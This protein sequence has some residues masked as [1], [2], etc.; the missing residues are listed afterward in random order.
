M[1][2]FLH[3]T[4][5]APPPPGKEAGHM[6]QGV[7]AQAETSR[8]VKSRTQT[9]T[10]RTLAQHMR[11]SIE[12]KNRVFRGRSYPNSFIGSDAI[13]YLINEGLVETVKDGES[14]GEALI[15]AGEIV[16]V[17]KEHG[18]KNKG[19]FYYFAQ[20]A[21][22]HGGVTQRSSS[23]PPQSWTHLFH[24]LGK[25]QT[26]TDSTYQPQIISALANGDLNSTAIDDL[27]NRELKQSGSTLKKLNI[28][29]L[30]KHNSTLLENVHPLSWKDPMPPKGKYNLVVL[31]G[32]T[33]GLVTAAGAAAVGARVALVEANLL[34]GDC[35]NA[36]CVP[37]KALLR[38]AKVAH[39]VRNCKEYGINIEG[40]ITVDF[41]AVMKRLR[42]LRASLA[43][44]DSA[45]RFSKLGVDVYM[46]HGS[47]TSKDI[48]T[49][50]G[51][52]LRFHR[53]VIATGG[54][55]NIPG[56][57]GLKSVPILTSLQVF[58]LTVLPPKI[59]IIGTGPVGCEMAQAFTRFGS[60]VH[61]FLR[62]D[63]PLR[64]EEIDAREVLMTALENDGVIF[65]KQIKFKKV[66]MAKEGTQNK[67]TMDKNKEFPDILISI[68]KERKI[69]TIRV[70]TVIVAAG[71]RPNVLSCGLDKAGVQFHPLRGI[72]I[73]D[74]LQTSNPAI[75]AVGDCAS[76]YHFTHVADHMARIAVRNALFFGSGRM[77]GLR[78]P[79]CTYTDP[80][81]AHVGEYERD[82]KRRKVEYQVQKKEFKDVDRS[83]V[84][85]LTTGFVKNPCLFFRYG[86]QILLKA[87]SDKILG[88]TIVGSY[89]GDMISEIS[90]AMKANMGLAELGSVIHPYPTA[91]EAIRACGDLYNRTRLTKTTH[92]LL[93]GLLEFRRT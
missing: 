75:Y 60:E 63:M 28:S 2:F 1:H 32:G 55:P 71:R 42:R 5:R 93:R 46:G 22:F 27:L 52:N 40:K 84:D 36:G 79:W 17:T 34:G 59:A 33:G 73:N 23:S 57:P 24:G 67:V 87:R 62:G 45:Q 66:E 56:I 43:P 41:G 12:L 15:K 21:P 72:K 91:A 30:D 68:I 69:E 50:N 26:R 77:S 78:I 80:Q 9:D 10:L 49:V 13:R 3:P 16:H 64:K 53:A 37:S 35:L 8:D 58:N 54:S 48:L 20:D 4:S 65:H 70:N 82:L 31:G 47:F 81:L 74:H 61:M 85:T 6:S 44:N 7:N 86:V 29:P 11:N 38:S 88:V 90:V 19:Y 92:R 14:L 25:P 89:A 83:V 76:A 51:K 39:T 18:L